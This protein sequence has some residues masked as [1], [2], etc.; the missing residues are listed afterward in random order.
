MECVSYSCEPE[1]IA[2]P[3]SWF[4]SGIDLSNEENTEKQQG[5]GLLPNTRQLKKVLRVMHTH[6]STYRDEAWLLFQPHVP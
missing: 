5:W 3:L 2:S 1:Q 4:L 6:W